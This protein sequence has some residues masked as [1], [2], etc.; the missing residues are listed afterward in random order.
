MELQWRVHFPLAVILPAT[1]TPGALLAALALLSMGTPVHS[2]E[3][4]AF[5]ID[6]RPGGTLTLTDR[7]DYSCFTYTTAA[8]W[9]INDDIPADYLILPQIFSYQ[10]RPFPVVA[11]GDRMVFAVR[12]DFALLAEFFPRG[13]EDYYLGFTF[14]PS[15]ELWFDRPA[16]Q[17][18]FM[19]GG[20]FGWTDHG[21][22]PVGLGRD[23]SFNWGFEL[24][25]KYFPNENFSLKLGV[26]F[27]H[28]SNMNTRE[29]NP[30]LNAL[31][32]TLGFS[33]SF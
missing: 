5:V 9:R 19:P 14:R 33:W 6:E 29:H 24:G 30:G 32:P 11:L 8:L 25:V 15:I 31:G 22:P 1:R 7:V 13:P 23:L 10:G 21:G 20:G 3:N 17:I 12:P 27:Q 4:S 16:M 26:Y 28:L 2:R 18:F